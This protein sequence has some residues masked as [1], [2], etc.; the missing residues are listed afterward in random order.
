MLLCAVLAPNSLFFHIYSFVFSKTK[1][2]MENY[3]FSFLIIFKC[4]KLNLTVAL[5]YLNLNHLKKL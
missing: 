4:F 5:N 1:E 2:L 3:S